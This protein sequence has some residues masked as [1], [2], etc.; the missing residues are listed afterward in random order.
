[1]APCAAPLT[2]HLGAA[3]QAVLVAAA[4]SS[5]SMSAALGASPALTNKHLW[6]LSLHIYAGVSVALLMFPE[7]Q[8]GVVVWWCGVPCRRLGR[9]HLRSLFC[10]VHQVSVNVFVMMCAGGWCVQQREALW[11]FTLS[12]IDLNKT[13]C[14]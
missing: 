4:L 6:A 9:A 7:K 8:R 2:A 3:L 12:S 11:I 10:D 1:M 14:V 5:L 13:D